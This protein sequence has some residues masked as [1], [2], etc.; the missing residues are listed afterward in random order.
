MFTQEL[1]EVGVM[2]C[3]EPTRGSAALYKQHYTRSC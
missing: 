2:R 3:H 1:R